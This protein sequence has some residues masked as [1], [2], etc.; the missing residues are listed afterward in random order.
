M[1]SS[2]E[3]RLQRL[4]RIIQNSENISQIPNLVTPVGN[5][6]ALLWSKSLGQNVSYPLSDILASGAIDPS[7]DIDFVYV[8]LPNPDFN[9]D[10]E[11][12]IASFI[13]NSPDFNKTGSQV[14]MFVATRLIIDENKDVGL[15]TQR[16]FYLLSLPK[17]T[18]G[19][20]SGNTVLSQNIVYQGS[21]VDNNSTIQQIEITSLDP[22]TI[23]N[24]VNTSRA[25]TPIG[26]ATLIFKID[27]DSGKRFD[28]Y[29]YQGKTNEDMGTGGYTSLSTDYIYLNTASASPSRPITIPTGWESKF[30]ATTQSLTSGDNLITI[31]GT[32]ESNGGLTLL[33][34]NGKVLP[35]QLGDS[36]SVDFGCTIVTPVGTNE[37][38]HLKFVVNSVVYRSIT[39]PLLKGSGNDDFISLTGTL[40]VGADFFANGLE[41]YIDASVAFDIKDKYIKAERNHIAK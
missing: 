35:T 31:T 21:L 1:P 20:T 7:N 26:S 36:V 12:Q 2:F 10:I 15:N 38:C 9:T 29:L 11:S 37:Y 28:Y 33:D 39:I 19:T 16:D 41:V 30:E 8:N 6:L 4:E 13:N 40:P 32:S 22:F 17:G 24:I 23:E 34:S 27:V 14:Y 25:F 5:E 18:Y 3:Q